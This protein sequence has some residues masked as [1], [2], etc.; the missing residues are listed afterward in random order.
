VFDDHGE[1][2]RGQAVRAVQY[3]CRGGHSPGDIRE[4]W[5]FRLSVGPPAGSA[6]L[7]TLRPDDGE[8]LVM[9]STADAGE[10]SPKGFGWTG[11]RVSAEHGDPYVEERLNQVFV[12]AA[13]V[14]SH[15]VAQ[16]MSMLGVVKDGNQLEHWSS[17]PN[18]QTNP[19]A[20]HEAAVRTRYQL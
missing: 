17:G 12:V 6:P 5:V 14:A 13:P 16:S 20:D 11:T 4:R 15:E 9:S 3:R 10:G 7:V 18:T 8:D 19:V 1:R 2:F